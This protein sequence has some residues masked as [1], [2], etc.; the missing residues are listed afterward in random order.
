MN[1]TP[2]N[3]TITKTDQIKSEFVIYCWGDC[4]AEIP[5]IKYKTKPNKYLSKK[6]QYFVQEVNQLMSKYEISYKDIYIYKS[7]MNVDFLLN[8]INKDEKIPKRYKP[9]IKNVEKS[10]LNI[11]MIFSNR[12]NVQEKMKNLKRIRTEYNKDNIDAKIKNVKDKKA[13]FEEKISS[14]NVYKITFK[15]A[16]IPLLQS[17]EYEKNSNH[18]KVIDFFIEFTR[19][20]GIDFDEYINNKARQLIKEFFIVDK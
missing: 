4:N 5:R 14:L 18:S 8:F 17:L 7:K 11:Q 1:I 15:S 13:F 16:L 10:A 19:K 3:R 2:T 9:I 20:D 12:K 6:I